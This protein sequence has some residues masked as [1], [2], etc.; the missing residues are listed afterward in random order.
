MAWRRL[1][2]ANAVMRCEAASPRRSIVGRQAPGG[3]HR[4]LP[5]DA[6]AERHVQRLSNLGRDVGLHLKDAGQGGIELLAPAGLG[7]VA[8]AHVY[9]SGVTRTRLAPPASRSHCTVVRR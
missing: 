5:S 1:A 4:K 9:Q 7:L 6:V 2:G 8:R 3:P